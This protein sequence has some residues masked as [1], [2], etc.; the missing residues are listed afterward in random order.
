MPNAELGRK[1]VGGIA[2]KWDKIEN[3]DEADR[4]FKDLEGKTIILAHNHFSMA[5]GPH[6]VANSMRF[7]SVRRSDI[8]VA[9]TYYLLKYAKA[10]DKIFHLHMGITGVVTPYLE[11]RMPEYRGRRMEGLIDFMRRIR[12]PSPRRKVIEI[13]PNATRELGPMTDLGD[14]NVAIQGLLK[15]LTRRNDNP[16]VVPAGM[17]VEGKK[18]E[19]LYDVHFRG[20]TMKYG[21]PISAEEIKR[22]LIEMEA[23][24]AEDFGGADKLVYGLIKTLVP[25]NYSGIK[26]AP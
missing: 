3:Y 6:G 5:D 12:T 24:K 4:N 22:Q 10:A 23:K 13:W 15:M 20:Y 9:V 1:F 21:T 25:E 14:E 2:G 19:E 18:P 8:E 17:W 16:Y 7:E 11:D 26:A